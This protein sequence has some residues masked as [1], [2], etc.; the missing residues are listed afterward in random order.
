MDWLK[1]R[2]ISAAIC[3]VHMCYSRKKNPFLG[4]HKPA[5]NYVGSPILKLSSFSLEDRLKIIF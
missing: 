5:S 1:T 4:W 2:S 3:Y